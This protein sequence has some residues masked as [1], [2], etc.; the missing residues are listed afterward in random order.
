MSLHPPNSI[1]VIFLAMRTGKDEE[2]Y[3]A[4][5][6]EM[7]ALAKQQSGYLGED[8]ARSEDGLGITISYWADDNAA[9]A[10][11][12]NARHASVREQGRGLWYDYYTL[13]VTRV[14]RSYRWQK[15]VTDTNM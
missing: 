11:R 13:H 9:K 6:N 2:G 7:S 1:A 10:W 12:D 5:A 15:P 14:E 3:Q 8:H 4:A